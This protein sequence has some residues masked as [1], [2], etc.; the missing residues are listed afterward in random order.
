MI[1]STDSTVR[2]VS[3]LLLFFFCDGL[4]KSY[5][6]CRNSSQMFFAKQLNLDRP[7]AKE[8]AHNYGVIDTE[9]GSPGL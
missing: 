8:M 3:L 5:L 2:G 6:R 1:S 9:N 4:V 7:I